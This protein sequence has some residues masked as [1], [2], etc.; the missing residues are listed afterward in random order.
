MWKKR[1]AIL[2]VIT[3]LIGVYAIAHSIERSKRDKSKQDF[4]KQMYDSMAVSQG[5]TLKYTLDVNYD[6]NHKN[7]EL[8]YLATEELDQVGQ[9]KKLTI[10][11]YGDYMGT[12]LDQSEIYYYEGT[13][14]IRETIFTDAEGNEHHNFEESIEDISYQYNPML[15]LALMISEMP[16]EFKLSETKKT[17][18]GSVALED[19][20][21]FLDLCPFSNLYSGIENMNCYDE[22]VNDL[23]IVADTETN[24]FKS[25]ALDMTTVSFY[26]L[27]DA[28]EEQGMAVK[29]KSYRMTVSVESWYT[30]GID[31]PD[32]SKETES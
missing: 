8:H 14:C 9:K 5:F 12:T 16:G 31:M 3:M 19:V 18:R 23:M 17:I 24:R 11:T 20:K 2:L 21:T 10:R 32:I 30:P 4:V 29:S 7:V 25:V 22:Q 26:M 27:R 15:P 28:Y 1:L 13:R 6:V